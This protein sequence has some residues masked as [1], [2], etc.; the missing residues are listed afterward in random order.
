[1]APN[2]PNHVLLEI[3]A[4]SLDYAVAG[5]RAGADRIEL[6][7][8]LDCGGV[9]PSARLMKAARERLQIPIHVLIRP[10]RGDF[11]YSPREF[12]TIRQSIQTAKD[13]K[14][15]GIVVGILD[16]N[17][18]VDVART[19]QLVELA[20]PLPVTFHR[21]FDETDSLHGSLEAVIRTGAQ[22]LLT[23]GGR[24]KATAALSTLAQ[25]VDKAND[26]LIVMPGSGITPANISRVV[27]ATSAREIHGT[28]L[29]PALRKE[30][31][32]AEKG[33]KEDEKG[34]KE[35]RPDRHLQ[36]ERYYRRVLK[37]GLMLESITTS[38]HRTS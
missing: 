19:R 7:S 20:Q 21:A 31:Q 34:E 33:R 1:M 32:K 16:R 30:N 13:L 28:L 15:D 29:T 8:D 11:V 9:T 35:D 3:C 5:Q 2:A 36:I 10:R 27:R 18:H 17:F 37:A 12:S 6:C 14:M 26:R 25:L 22:R 24:S 38:R 23:S 4:T